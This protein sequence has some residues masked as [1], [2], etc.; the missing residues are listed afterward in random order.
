[1]APPAAPPKMKDGSSV[2]KIS[3]VAIKGSHY[4]GKVLIGLEALGVPWTPELIPGLNPAKELAG[5]KKK[6]ASGKPLTTV[7]IMEIV[8]WNGQEK[9]VVAG[10]DNILKWVDD[11]VDGNFKFYPAGLP[12][13][14][15]VKEL[16][17]K[18]DRLGLWIIFWHWVSDRG[19][20]R[21]IRAKVPSLLPFFIRWVSPDLLPPIKF[22]R[23]RF[24]EL[25]SKN[26][27]EVFDSREIAGAKKKVD[28]EKAMMLYT[29]EMRNI[30]KLFETDDQKFVAGTST[31]SAADCMLAAFLHSLCDTNVDADIPPCTP[32]LLDEVGFDHL[33][34]FFMMM[35]RDYPFCF[36]PKRKK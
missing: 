16:E 23:K 11:N 36:E 33:K 2:P 19:F 1:M 22:N 15:K 32:G 21:T 4:V 9:T 17:S 30:S 29:E 26:M 14:E 10:S 18:F 34:K 35:K 31:P 25:I 6:D 3:I 8:Q 12:E 7:P 20:K 28:E 27:P 24:A 13:N 5:K